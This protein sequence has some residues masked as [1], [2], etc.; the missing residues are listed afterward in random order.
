MANDYN[1]WNYED[2]KYNFPDYVK[3]D[4]EALRIMNIVRYEMNASGTCTS[5]MLK[6]REVLISEGHDVPLRV[7]GY[8][9]AK[10]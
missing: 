2:V 1:D 9:R 8:G 6:V 4:D 5:I 3:R 10:R 7:C